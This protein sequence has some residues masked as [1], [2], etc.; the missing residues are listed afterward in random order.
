MDLAL[1][2]GGASW[3]LTVLRE[4]SITSNI[5]LQD[6]FTSALITIKLGEITAQIRSCRK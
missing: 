4:S 6:S 2:V 5:T 1:E 3:S